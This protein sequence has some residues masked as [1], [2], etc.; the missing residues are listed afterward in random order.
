MFGKI[1]SSMY[2]GSMVGAG[3]VVFAVWGYVISKHQPP[4]H[5]VD[6]NSKLLAAILG[7]TDV[8]VEKA[9]EYLCSPDPLS[10]TDEEQGKRLIKVGALTYHVV[11]GEKYHNIR[12]YEER[13]EYNRQAQA[14]YREKKKL[15]GIE[16]PEPEPPKE[17]KI[18]RYP[19]IE[20]CKLLAVKSGMPEVEGEKFFNHYESNGWRVGKNLMKSVNGSM[21]GWKLRVKDYENNRTISTGAARPIQ[22]V[23]GST[24][25]NG[26]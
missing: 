3:A 23:K 21:A 12:N 9:I 5:N 7:E 14:K 17:R 11:K 19:T 26:F 15:D 6:L 22:P 18:N 16:I 24:A 4:E 13:K 1:F 20:E 10:H 8:E 25:V 2:E